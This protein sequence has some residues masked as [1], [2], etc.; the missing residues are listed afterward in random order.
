MSIWHR[1]IHPITHHFRQQRGQFI[2]AAFPHI[3]TQ[4]ICDLG[5]SR[6]FWD[7]LGLAVPR[8]HITIYNISSGETQG[9]NAPAGPPLA[10]GDIQVLIYD[11]QHLPVPDK[12]FD[13]LVCNSVLEH[14][15]P[16]Q[17][18][19]LAREM[20]RVAKSIFCQTPARSFPIEP[21]FLMPFVH[22]LPRGLGFQLIKISPWR[23]LSRPSPQ[24][25]DEYWW[26]TQLLSEREVAALF[27]N[28]RVQPERLLGLTKSYYVVEACA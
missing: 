24:T 11:G 28:A 7:K 13:L 16:A 15:P 14:V 6:H 20:R 5:G 8:Q 27:P 21:H 19:A 12:H 1:V 9:M 4:R 18:P 25:M 10:D 2:R 17:R 3:A 22:W 23:L 26:G